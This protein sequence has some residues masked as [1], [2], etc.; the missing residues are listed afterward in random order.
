[1]PVLRWSFPKLFLFTLGCVLFLLALFPTRWEPYQDYRIRFVAAGLL[2]VN[3]SIVF[4]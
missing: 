4:P 3:I 2:F 1:M